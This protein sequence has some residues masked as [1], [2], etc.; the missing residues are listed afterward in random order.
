MSKRFEFNACLK[1]GGKIFGLITTEEANRIINNKNTLSGDI[2]LTDKEG[3]TIV[4][5][6]KDIL[7]WYII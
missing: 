5:N 4:V 6:S 7:Y 3:D 1:K 2:K